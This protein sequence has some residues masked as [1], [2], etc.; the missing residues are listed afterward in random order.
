MNTCLERLE[1]YFTENRVYYEI[2]EHRTAYTIQEVA[3]ALHEKG[4]HVAKV[5]IAYAGEQLIMLVLPA[6]ARVD[7]ERVKVMLNTPHVRRA[8]EVEFANVFGDCDVG[9]MP[10][11]GNLYGV[12]VY[13][14]CT[15]ADQP[16]LVFQAGSHRTTM[17]IAMSDYWRLAVPHIGDFCVQAEPRPTTA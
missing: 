17:K 12:P 7:L 9:A 13:L 3:A 15:L 2:Q 8:R 10:P 6:P 11:F 14:D 5:F 4:E 1:H 16:Y